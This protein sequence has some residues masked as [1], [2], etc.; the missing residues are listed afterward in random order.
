MVDTLWCSDFSW[1]VCGYW[2]GWVKCR[3]PGMACLFR[4][5]FLPSTGLAIAYILLCVIL[6]IYAASAGLSL[7][8]VPVSKADCT[9]SCTTLH[10]CDYDALAN[11]PGITVTHVPFTWQGVQLDA[12]LLQNN[13]VPSTGA[14]HPLHVLYNHGS[15]WN[16]AAQYRLTRYKQLLARG[17]M[18]L[19]TWDYPGYGDS[20]GSLSVAGVINSGAG[21]YNAFSELLGNSTAS[22]VMLGRSMGGPVSAHTIQGLPRP[23][24]PAGLVLQ[25]TFADFDQNLRAL[26]PVAG[27]I[28]AAV[29]DVDITPEEWLS[30]YQGCVFSSISKSDEW[31]DYSQGVQL[32][33]GITMKN[34]Q[35]S[36]FWPITDSAHDDDMKPGQVQAL[37]TWMDQPEL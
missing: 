31:V 27:W 28:I 12:Y 33:D 11:L 36:T 25:S 13:T 20:Q 14:T 8:F 30:Q 24:Q 5:F 4:I 29:L 1:Y 3:F 19:F 23:A 32:Y 16:V 2:G 34:T 21:A 10:C 26:Y 35:C 15:G 37:H 9:G 7:V 17:N 18:K 22:M 6:A